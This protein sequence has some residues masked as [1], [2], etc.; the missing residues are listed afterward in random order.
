[1]GYPG[2]SLCD[3]SRY[4]SVQVGIS[5][6]TS[7]LIS[8]IS[9]DMMPGYPSLSDFGESYPRLSSR[10]HVQNCWFRALE[11]SNRAHSDLDKLMEALFFICSGD[12]R[13]G[14]KIKLPWSPAAWQSPG[15]ARR[16]CRAQDSLR[17][18][19]HPVWHVA[20]SSDSRGH[21]ARLQ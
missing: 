20:P 13:T 3:I 12:R 7:A 9:R 4:Y 14:W 1:M 17:Q 2:I 18:L 11:C 15:A 5:R 21:V 8:G 10:M 16:P 6:N 19:R